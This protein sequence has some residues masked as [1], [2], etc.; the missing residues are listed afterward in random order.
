MIESEN[1]NSL[2]KVRYLGQFTEKLFRSRSQPSLHVLTQKLFKNQKQLNQEL[3]EDL[4]P[5]A[6]DCVNTNN[7]N[8]NFLEH[9]SPLKTGSTKAPIIQFQDI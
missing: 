2:T 1:N 7:N 9:F 6:D 8:N 5:F 3:N 4:V